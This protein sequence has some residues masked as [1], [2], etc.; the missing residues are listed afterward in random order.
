MVR[1]VVVSWTG[2]TGTLDL[3]S[4]P[5]SI[6]SLNLGSN[7][8]TGSISFERLPEWMQCSNVSNNELSGS[9][10]LE[11]L[12]KAMTDF[13]ASTNQ[14][15]G[16][17]DLTRLPASLQSLSLIENHLSVKKSYLGRTGTARYDAQKTRA[18]ALGMY[19][20]EA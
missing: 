18:P 19:Q 11:S 8:F 15:S 14:F 13:Y 5:T 10:K 4:L 2:L 3:A 16:S 17:V 9:F 20:A 1:K 6:K 7:R 12:P